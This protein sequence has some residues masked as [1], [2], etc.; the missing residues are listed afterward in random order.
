MPPKNNSK[1]SYYVTMF[2]LSMSYWGACGIETKGSFVLKVN[3][4]E[5]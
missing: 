3:T 2:I 4:L 1:D 5:S